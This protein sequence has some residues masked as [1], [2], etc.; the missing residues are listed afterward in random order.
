MRTSGPVAAAEKEE[1]GVA[2]AKEKGGK[3]LGGIVLLGLAEH[4]STTEVGRN[5]IK[6]SFL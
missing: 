3:Q 2:E 4:K 1:E 5:W 6:L